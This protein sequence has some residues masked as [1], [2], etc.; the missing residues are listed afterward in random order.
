MIT[1]RMGPG[2]GGVQG[3]DGGGGL[4][5][6]TRRGP[7]LCRPTYLCRL[8]GSQ[9]KLESMQSSEVRKLTS[10]AIPKSTNVRPLKT[11]PGGRY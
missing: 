1:H 6:R 7:I 4:Q 2:W 8:C 3:G 5:Q 11:I 10:V 9:N